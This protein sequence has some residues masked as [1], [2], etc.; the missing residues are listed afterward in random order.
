M[1]YPTKGRRKMHPADVAALSQIAKAERF[2]V[3]FRLNPADLIRSEQPSL[4]AAIAEAT[5]IDTGARARASGR[6]SIIYAV[7]DQGQSIPVPQDV[8][9]DAR[10]CTQ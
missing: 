5:R 9:K 2:V 4:V 8:I 1:S 10:Q 7:G 3:W 6:R